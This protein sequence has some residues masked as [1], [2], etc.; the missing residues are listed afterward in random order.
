MVNII[1]KTGT[2]V[3]QLFKIYKKMKKAMKEEGQF[4]ILFIMME[5]LDLMIVG[6]IATCIRSFSFFESEKQEH[7]RGI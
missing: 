1:V 5:V 3:F 6:E 4:L 7:F 2:N